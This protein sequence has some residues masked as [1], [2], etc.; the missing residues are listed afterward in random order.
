MKVV[1][2]A[3]AMVISFVRVSGAEMCSPIECAYTVEYTEPTTNT[4]GSPL[5]NLTETRLYWKLGSGGTE[6]MVTTLASTPQGGGVIRR[7]VMVPIPLGTNVNIYIS[8]TAVSPG[9]ESIRTSIIEPKLRVGEVKPSVPTEISITTDGETAK[10]SWIPVEGTHVHRVYILTGIHWIKI[11]EGSNSRFLLTL[12]QGNVVRWMVV[13]V[14]A[15]GTEIRQ[16]HVGI[17]TTK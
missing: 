3:L 2:L 13:D 7:V 1:F 11:A 5:T 4:D 10:I 6:M 14:R 8:A 15:D 16:E 17:W 9:G 12:P